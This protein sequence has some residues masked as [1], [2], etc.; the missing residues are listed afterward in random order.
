MDSDQHRQS[1][2]SVGVSE[3]QQ[4]QGSTREERGDDLERVLRSEEGEIRYGAIQ[5]SRRPCIR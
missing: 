5:Q 1:M 4:S 2:Q 3:L